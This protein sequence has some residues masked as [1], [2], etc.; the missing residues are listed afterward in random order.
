MARVTIGMGLKIAM[1]FF[2]PFVPELFPQ[3]QVP[4]VMLLCLVVMGA[5]TWMI[6]GTACQV[7]WWRIPEREDFFFLFS[8]RSRRPFPLIGCWSLFFSS[9]TS[10]IDFLFPLEPTPTHAHPH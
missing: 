5:M 8:L 3:S 2:M 7:R 1:L 4:T 9:R 10:L 6:H